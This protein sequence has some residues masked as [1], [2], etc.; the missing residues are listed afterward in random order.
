MTGE[1][2]SAVLIDVAGHEVGANM[3]WTGP[4]SAVGGQITEQGKPFL[5]Y[6]ELRHFP[7]IAGC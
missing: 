5:P 1:N 2:P 3:R 4:Q 7:L 6:F